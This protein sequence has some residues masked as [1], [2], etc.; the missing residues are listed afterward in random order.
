MSIL[1]FGGLQG[2]S[3]RGTHEP[4]ASGSLDAERVSHDA[5]DDLAHPGPQIIRRVGG[6]AKRQNGVAVL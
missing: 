1:P 6:C 3:G 2:A 4:S 5:R